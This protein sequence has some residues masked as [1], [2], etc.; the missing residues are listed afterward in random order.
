M[1]DD[2]NLATTA[3]LTSL[4]PYNFL[5]A[6]DSA[7]IQNVYEPLCLSRY[8]E[9]EDGTKTKY[10]EMLLAEDYSISED[11]TEYTFNLK[12]GVKFHNGE[13]LKASDVVFSYERALQAP[14]MGVYA[15]SIAAVEAVGD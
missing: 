8:E 14:L 1:R 12:Q 2:L 10:Y 6:M 13:E 9:N 3:A 7:M 15:S 11:A 5:S 4:D